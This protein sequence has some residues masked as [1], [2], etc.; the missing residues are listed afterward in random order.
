MWLGPTSG[1]AAGGSFGFTGG[2]YHWNWGRS[3]IV[4]LVSNAIVWT[5]GA[6]IPADGLA[7]SGAPIEVLEAGQD[8]APPSS[9]D[10]EKTREEFQV[11]QR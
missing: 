5:T 7:V 3:D 9:F 1:R 6:D 8:E 2:H 4:K 11:E 10:A